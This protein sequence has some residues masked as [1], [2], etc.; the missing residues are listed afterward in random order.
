MHDQ[1]SSSIYEH[2]LFF[3][4]FVRGLQKGGQGAFR[5]E[6]SDVGELRASVPD[7]PVM[8]LAATASSSV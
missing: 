4:Y 3:C 5:P 7:V 1:A 2:I 8:A 6:F